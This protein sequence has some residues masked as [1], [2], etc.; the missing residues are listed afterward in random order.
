MNGKIFRL[1]GRYPIDELH[2][3]INTL[4][5]RDGHEPVGGLGLAI[6]L[7]SHFHESENPRVREAL[8]NIDRRIAA[9]DSG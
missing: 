1:M 4:R 8:A 3:E 6:K 7:Q 5:Q 9:Q 2:R